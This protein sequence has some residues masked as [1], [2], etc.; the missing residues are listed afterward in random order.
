MVL[1]QGKRENIILSILKDEW[2]GGV[3]DKLEKIPV[4]VF[5]GRTILIL[6]KNKNK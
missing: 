4:K 1:L 2:F 3:K 5:Y 6:L